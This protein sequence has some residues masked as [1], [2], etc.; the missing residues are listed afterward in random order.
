MIAVENISLP[1]LRITSIISD[2]SEFRYPGD[3]PQYPNRHHSVQQNAIRLEVQCNSQ[4][5]FGI[6][7]IRDIICV[8]ELLP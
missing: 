1:K 6:A 5:L 3:L 7:C 8:F 2:Q 4:G